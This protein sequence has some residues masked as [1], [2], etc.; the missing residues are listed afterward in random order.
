[1]RISNPHTKL[2]RILAK[3]EPGIEYTAS[4]IAYIT[5]FSR[6]EVCGQLRKATD[7]GRVEIVGYAASGYRAN[8]TTFVYRIK[9]VENGS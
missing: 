8:M 7:T 9:E 2:E 6:C 4:E 1:M 5:G 3:M